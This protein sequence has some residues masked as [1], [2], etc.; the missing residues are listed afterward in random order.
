MDAVRCGRGR[1]WHPQQARRQGRAARVIQ[2]SQCLV[3]VRVQIA[4][5]RAPV[6]ARN[7]GRRPCQVKPGI[8]GTTERLVIVI[9]VV[10]GLGDP[11]A[12]RPSG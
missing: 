5:S 10:A 11:V 7:C 9:V 12:A 1:L 4:T 6:R 8:T 2:D 3:S